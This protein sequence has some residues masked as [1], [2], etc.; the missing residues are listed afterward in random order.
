MEFKC[1]YPDLNMTS[2]CYVILTNIYKFLTKGNVS[3]KELKILCFIRPFSYLMSLIKW[4]EDTLSIT[5]GINL[6]LAPQISEH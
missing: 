1:G 4:A 5:I 2:L 3:I 6:W